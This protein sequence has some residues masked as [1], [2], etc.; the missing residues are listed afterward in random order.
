MNLLP[1]PREIKRDRATEIAFPDRRWAEIDEVTLI[2]NFAARCHSLI[3]SRDFRVSDRR[4]QITDISAVLDALNTAITDI[5]SVGSDETVECH[6]RQ[7]FTLPAGDNKPVSYPK[8]PKTV[9][10][11]AAACDRYIPTGSETFFDMPELDYPARQ[12]FRGEEGFKFS[13]AEPVFIVGNTTNP[14]LH[15]IRTRDIAGIAVRALS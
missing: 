13:L 5:L 7:F 10:S 1:P 14:S 9:Q 15:L 3:A 8:L 4:T 6:C 11:Q 12:P 2:G